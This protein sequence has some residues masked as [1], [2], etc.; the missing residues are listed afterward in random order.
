MI[1]GLILTGL[2]AMIAL[3]AVLWGLTYMWRGLGIQISGHGHAAL[4]LG[5]VATIA[6]SC[7]LFA[8][9]FFSSRRGHDDAA[10]PRDETTKPEA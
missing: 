7:G 6:L 8:L 10:V 5:G 3:A 2:G 1:R 9:T 4:I